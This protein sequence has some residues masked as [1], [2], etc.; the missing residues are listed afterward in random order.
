MHNLKWQQMHSLF[1]LQC[2]PLHT[3][4]S[5]LRLGNLKLKLPHPLNLNPRVIDGLNMQ[6]I[7]LFHLS[8]KLM[9]K[10]DLHP[11]KSSY[12]SASSPSSRL[13]QDPL[14]HRTAQSHIQW[15]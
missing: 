11:N 13:S 7:A 3:V 2:H 1:T 9:A 6:Y 12:K 14:L 10:I 4:L 5:K 8:I 15:C